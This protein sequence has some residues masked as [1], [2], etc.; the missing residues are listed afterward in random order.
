MTLPFFNVHYNTDKVE[1]QLF[2]RK[3]EFIIFSSL[4]SAQTLLIFVCVYALQEI[5]LYLTYDQLSWE[6]RPAEEEGEE[7]YSSLLL[8]FD[9]VLS[10]QRKVAKRVQIFSRQAPMMDAMISRC[11]DSV[12]AK[13][14]ELRQLR[15]QQGNSE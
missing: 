14:E 13:E 4:L 2:T 12:N 7:F 9:S 6:F 1:S 10:D 11:V 5:L 3:I 15:L 8:E